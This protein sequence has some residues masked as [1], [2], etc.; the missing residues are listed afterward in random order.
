[1][2]ECV[3]IR[4]EGLSKSY[5]GVL[6]L[7]AVSLEIDPGQIVA[8]LGA[9]GA[10]KT[11]LLRCL[12]GIAAPSRGRIYYDGEQFFRKRVDLRRRLSFLPDFPPM[13]AHMTAGRHIAM[14]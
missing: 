11:T 14:A 5:G 9:N 7:D 10:G 8:V 6:A 12:A 13:F 1:M 4:T 3:K 2:V